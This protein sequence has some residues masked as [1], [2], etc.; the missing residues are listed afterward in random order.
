M[1]DDESYFLYCCQYETLIIIKALLSY[2]DFQ[3]LLQLYTEKT[4]QTKLVFKTSILAK[5]TLSNRVSSEVRW[6]SHFRVIKL[7]CNFGL[8]WF[9]ENRNM[10]FSPWIVLIIGT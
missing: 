6:F 1:I 8:S 9:R 4:H 2:K 3:R 5:D 7:E 10:Q